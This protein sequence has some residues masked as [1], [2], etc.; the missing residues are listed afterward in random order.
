MGSSHIYDSS[1]AY[2]QGFNLND[3]LKFN[4]YWLLRVGASQDWFHTNNFNNKSVLT[5]EY[6]NHGI[7]PTGSIIFKPAA[8]MS[9]YATYTNSLQAGDLAP[10]GTV[11]AGDSLAP[12]RSKQYEV[13]YKVDFDTINF[14]AALFDLERPFANINPLNNTFEITGDQVNKGLEL[15]AVGEVID[16]LTMYGGI[17]LL[18]SSWRT[19]RWPR[20]MT[21]CTSARRRSRAT[22]CLSTTCRHFPGWW[23]PST[24]SSRARGPAM[25]PISSTVA[26]Y[27]LFDVGARYTLQDVGHAGRLAPGGGQRD[28]PA[29]LVH[30][31]A[32]QHHGCQYRQSGGPLGAPRTLEASV[33][34]KF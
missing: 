23:R 5:T 25:T 6:S 18:N 10:A 21:S 16:G 17:T 4:D 26:G 28:R 14:T 30:H 20:P 8:N 29:L 13:G 22:C 15:S 3:T 9:V 2:Q 11:N 24:T 27:N 31:R 34:V 1:D 7:S 12:Y 19:P 32:E 33:T